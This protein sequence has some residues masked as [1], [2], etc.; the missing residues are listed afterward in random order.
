MTVLDDCYV[1]GHEWTM[2]FGC[3][4]ARCGFYKHEVEGGK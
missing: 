1:F 3:R 4:C 2:E